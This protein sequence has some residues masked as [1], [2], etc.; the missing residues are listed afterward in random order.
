MNI[1][2]FS[3]ALMLL[4]CLLPHPGWS[5]DDAGSSEGKAEPAQAVAPASASAQ[6][7]P[8][9]APPTEAAPAQTA[10]GQTAPPAERARPLTE[11]EDY[12]LKRLQNQLLQVEKELQGDEAN[13]YSRSVLA[14]TCSELALLADD[15]RSAFGLLRR[16]RE[17]YDASG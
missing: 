9:P 8:V 2:G 16:A 11:D 6:T 5:A 1:R 17:I 12:S 13:P 14:E 7:P 4:A 10:S 3:A 15:A